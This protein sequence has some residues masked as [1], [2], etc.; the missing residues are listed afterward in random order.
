[1][2][3]TT[4]SAD[5]LISPL[6][7]WCLLAFTFST[8]IIDAVSWLGLD[9]VFTANM[10]G[11]VLILGMGLA[12]APGARGFA[13]F[14]SIAAFVLGAGLIGFVQRRQPSTWTQR[15]TL[16]FSIVAAIVLVLAVVTMVL[17]PHRG[18]PAGYVVMGVLA[19]AMGIQGGEAVRI[20]VPQITTVAVSSAVAGIGLNLFLGLRGTRGAH[21][22]RRVSA[23]VLLAL[24]AAAGS[25]LMSIGFG[26]GLAVAG[27][28]AA[29]AV[30]VG[31]RAPRTA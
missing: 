6:Q 29:G 12:D 19:F 30:I 17:P 25:L 20:G 1:M 3:G 22:L 9:S 27:V 5:G 24:G 2:P 8:G 4:S 21:M 7:V 15:T 13:A 11:N 16:A 14:C 31:H 23:V 28:I 26:V 18:T 10:T